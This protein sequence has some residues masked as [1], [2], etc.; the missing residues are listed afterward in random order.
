MAMATASTIATGAE[1]GR[2]RRNSASRKLAA[3]AAIAAGA[4]AAV[5][6]FLPASLATWAAVDHQRF[7]ASIAPWNAA[8]ASA[9]AAAIPA[10]PRKPEIR[11]LV[12]SSLR[13]DVTQVEAIEL[14]ALDLAL[15][16][17]TAQARGL[18]QLSNRLS[19]R[20]LATRLWLIQDAVDRGD[21]GDAL[22]NFD[23]ALRTTTDAQPILFPVLTR[24]SADPRLTVAIA[25]TLDRPSDW[26][27]M[28]VDWAL[29]NAADVAPVAKVVAH[30]R[31]GRFIVGN[32]L[33][34][35]LINR[36]VSSDEFD[37]AKMLNQ[38]FG[39]SEAGVADPDFA[40]LAAHYPF[41]WGLVSNGSIGAERALSGSRTMLTYRAAPANSGQVAAQL[42]TL[43]EGKYVLATRTAAT[44]IGAAPYWSLS[45]GELPNRELA[46]LDQPMKT[47]GRAEA[48]F[49]VPQGCSGQWLTL[50]VRPAADASQQSGAIAFVSVSAR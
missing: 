38:R 35:Q 22:H 20:S 49:T 33:D 11:A 3:R 46:R 12:A 41:G 6:L 44:P 23:I 37:Q 43:K 21:V 9:A 32:S 36:L 19:R 5:V 4:I 27:L 50:R 17:K 13:R 14:R 42:L 47:D 30:M 16:G 29:S 15:S 31:D 1:E 25:R 10:D 24:A 34:Q 2:R 7:A 39:H 18:F 8:A 48:V 28:F 40:D 26:R 45:C